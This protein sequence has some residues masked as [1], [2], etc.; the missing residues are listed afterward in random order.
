[1]GRL[2]AFSGVDAVWTP[3]AA[4]TGGTFAWDGTSPAGSTTLNAVARFEGN[5]TYGPAESPMVTIN[6]PR[7]A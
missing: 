5:A 4:G 6:Q 7:L 3:V 2:L 1:M